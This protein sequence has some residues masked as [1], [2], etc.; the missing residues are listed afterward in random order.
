MVGKGYRECGSSQGLITRVSALVGTMGHKVSGHAACGPTCLG[1][2][3]KPV[4]LCAADPIPQL[5]LLPSPSP[6]TENVPHSVPRTPL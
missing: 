3:Q 2:G 6:G 1:K 5:Q 4:K